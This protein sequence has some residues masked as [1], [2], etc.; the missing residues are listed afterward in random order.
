[1]A[2]QLSL[3][4]EFRANKTFDDFF[5]GINQ[6]IIT[7]LKNYLLDD[8]EQQIFICGKPGL[9][10][11]HLLQACCHQA[12]KQKLSAFY[13]ALSDKGLPDPALLVGLDKF[14]L[15]CFDN[16]DYIAGDPVWEQAFFNFFNLHRSSGHKLILSAACV[17]NKMAIQLAD[18]KS[19]LNW[20]LTLKLKPLPDTDKITAL[21]FKANQLGFA[22]TPQAGQFLLAHYD[23]D[24]VN[25]WA[26]LDKLDRASLAAKCKLTI[27]F[28]KKFLLQEGIDQQNTPPLQ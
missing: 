24:L 26:L 15:V 2:E 5:P 21:I 14:D 13:F 6:E 11:T 10:K 8:K 4:F 23:R 17:P 7:H 18:L 9:G 1:M 20:G 16:I 25:L 19:R 27:P 12:H 3:S 28:L 22:I